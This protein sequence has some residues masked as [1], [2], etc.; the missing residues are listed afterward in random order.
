MNSIQKLK[1]K[2]RSTNEKNGL[3]ESDVMYLHGKPQISVDEFTN[4]TPYSAKAN[5]VYVFISFSDHPKHVIFTDCITERIT[6]KESYEKH[7]GLIYEYVP[8]TEEHAEIFL[9]LF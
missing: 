4:I 5:P 9:K 2:I 6:D 3:E 1:E 7:N 8:I